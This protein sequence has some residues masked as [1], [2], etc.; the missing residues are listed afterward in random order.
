MDL[1]FFG[2]Y[3]RAQYQELI[4]ELNRIGEWAKLDQALKLE[5]QAASRAFQAQTASYAATVDAL[6]GSARVNRA[7]IL[8]LEKELAA[9]R[10]TTTDWATDRKEALDRI[11]WLEQ[12]ERDA[13]QALAESRARYGDLEVDYQE[14]VDR[15]A[16]LEGRL[17][18]LQEEHTNTVAILHNDRKGDTIRRLILTLWVSRRRAQARIARAKLQNAVPLSAFDNPRNAALAVERALNGDGS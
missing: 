12:R 17:A 13:L 16:D 7:R 8:F 4:D 14:A 5:A 1:R 18:W 3:T 9:F 6:D 11:A 10:S 2:L 15:V